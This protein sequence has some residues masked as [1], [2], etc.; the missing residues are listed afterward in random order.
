MTF[1]GAIDG[2]IEK[3]AEKIPFVDGKG[4]FW[5]RYVSNSLEGCAAG[6][7]KG[8]EGKFAP[9]H[10]PI[11]MGNFQ[12]FGTVTVGGGEEVFH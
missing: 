2:T 1:S 5:K 12:G 4:G 7:G 9:G 11:P 6:L 3:I 8:H 10:C